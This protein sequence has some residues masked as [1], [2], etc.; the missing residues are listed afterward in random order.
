MVNDS[1]TMIFFFSGP[2]VGGSSALLS[3]MVCENDGNR[4]IETKDILECGTLSWLTITN[5]EKNLDATLCRMMST[6]YWTTIYTLILLVI[7]I[8]CNTTEPGSVLIAT[9]I[10]FDILFWS[11]LILVHDLSK[12]NIIFFSTICFMIL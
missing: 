6:I 4:I 5:L 2:F 3:L 1:F 9:V 11:D 12:L 7:L 10:S 8:I